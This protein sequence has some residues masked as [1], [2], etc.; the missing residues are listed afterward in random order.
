MLKASSLEGL[1]VCEGSDYAELEGTAKY[2]FNWHAKCMISSAET[3]TIHEDI[4]MN[5]TELQFGVEIE[6]IAGQEARN[7]GLRV[8]SFSAAVQV[9]YLPHGWK[10]KTD[11]SINCPN[12]NQNGCE[13]VSPILRGAQGLADVVAACQALREKGHIVNQSC[14]VHVHIGW[15][16]D[17]REVNA[18]SLKRLITIV[19]YLEKGL[20]AI[21]G[22]KARER[23]R[24][25]KPVRQYLRP[26]QAQ[27]QVTLDR[28]HA[29]NLNNIRPNG[30]QT[31]E[32]RIFS[33]SISAT[34]IVGWIQVCL[35]IVERAQNGKRCP[36]WSPKPLK[37]G[38]RK[39]GEGAGECERL[40]GYLA[41][42]DAY[43]RRH[44]GNKYGLIGYGRKG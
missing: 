16:Q 14:G 28:Y 33:G 34:K 35:G 23:G 27:R 42:S 41:W 25:S 3:Q 10:A 32:F 22:T 4:Q 12:S 9:P 11:G 39:K 18:E 6:T 36:S 8:G 37:G 19:A 7:A 38:W 31:V 44:G 17:R 1:V 2:G 15:N 5:A 29:L 43:S 26:T 40:L 30:K 24:Y 13:V 20:Y 21:T